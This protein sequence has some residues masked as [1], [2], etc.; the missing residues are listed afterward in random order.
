ML[1]PVESS[2]VTK[3]S[4]SPAV[5]GYAGACVGKFVELVVPAMYKL[6]AKSTAML[7]ARSSP[8]PPR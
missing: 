8:L 5:A 7:L 4:L 1:C 2:F 6:F 3:I